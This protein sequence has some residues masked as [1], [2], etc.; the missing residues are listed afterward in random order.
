MEKMLYDNRELS[1]LKF[2]KRVLEEAEDKR[3]PLC[4]RLSFVSIFQSN[5]DEFTMVRVGSLHAGELSEAR[6]NKTGMTCKEQL[7][8][9]GKEIK[10]LLEYKDK[11]YENLM[12]ELETY[13][14]RELRFNDLTEEEKDKVWKYFEQEVRP[15]L[16]P[17]IVGKRQPFPFLKNQEIYAVVELKTKSNNKK[18]GIIP[19][20][21]GVLKRVIPVSADG[22][23]FMLMEELILHFVGEIFDRY[24]VESKSL[25]RI[26][27]NADIDVDEAVGDDED[28][29]RKAVEEVLKTRKRLAPLQLDFTRVMDDSIIVRMCDYLMLNK[30]QIY[31]SE[32]PLNL[33]FLFQIQD[34]LRDRKELFFERRIP[35]KSPMIEER[36]SMIEQI[37]EKDILLSYPYESMR[38]FLHLLNEAASDPAVVSIKMT[39]YRLAN[40][41]KIVE[42]LVEAA[43]NGKEVI[44]L[45]EL[46]ARFDEEN[47]IRWSKQLEDAGC[48]VIYGL[49]HLKVHSKLCLITRKGKEQ[50]EYIT[51]IGTGNY[52]EKTSKIYTDY[53]FMTSM[54]EIGVEAGMIFNC[55]SMGR[56][57]D[58][59]T[60]LFVAPNC[61]RNK[62]LDLIQA[63]I[64]KVK[65]G[66]QGY[67][68]LKLNSLT[69]K[70]LIDK[71]IEAGQKGV[72]IQ[73][74]VRGIC[75]LLAGIE[76][77]TDNIEVI[78]IVGRYLEHSRIYIF[79]K[80]KEAKVY[81]ASADFMTRNTIKRVEVA[82]PI[83]DETIKDRILEDFSMYL[84]DDVKARQQI[85]GTYV[86]KSKEGK[87]NAQEYFMERAYKNA[88]ENG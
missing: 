45:V 7:A 86:R 44:V 56:T 48:R 71:L 88:S 4:E 1:W 75:C 58:G 72:K 82:A 42:A 32:A 6:E 38:P 84:A 69:D 8:E 67:I 9:I 3:N 78:S 27:R 57:V 21:N 39:L 61:L 79:G 40:N 16:S 62:I 53:S 64:D 83:Y 31:H 52:N 63:E 34:T 14:V 30:N 70:V 29:Y 60:H 47:N 77:K 13:G 2:N 43:E 37:K 54:S 10:K 68:G 12:K 20:S 17:Q 73:M 5:L 33:S 23:R 22:R 35:Q 36:R 49:S 55:L 74:V 66:G 15:F 24:L 80:E 25:I 50:I 26:L 11:V 65:G 51:Q 87:I 28:D 81:I 18:I 85:D 59:T 46:R 41:S 76:G 19:C